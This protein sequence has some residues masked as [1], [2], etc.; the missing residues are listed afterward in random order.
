MSPETCIEH[1]PTE[2]ARRLLGAADII[3]DLQDQIARMEK[4][5]AADHRG[6]AASRREL[7][8]YIGRLEDRLAAAEVAP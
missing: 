8:E 7:V 4:R 2:A 3:R 5:H 6:W 1:E